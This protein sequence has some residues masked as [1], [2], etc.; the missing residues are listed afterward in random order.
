M[1]NRQGHMMFDHHGQTYWENNESTIRPLGT[2][3]LRGSALPICAECFYSCL[4]RCRSLCSKVLWIHMYT[5]VF[6][7]DDREPYELSEF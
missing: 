6:A 2:S 7:L 1:R 3:F 4:Q 5:C